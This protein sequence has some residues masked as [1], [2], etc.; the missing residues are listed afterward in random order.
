MENTYRVVNLPKEPT[1]HHLG[2]FGL[3][4]IKE[5][6]PQEICEAGFNA[7]LPYFVKATPAVEATPVVEAAPIVEAEPVEEVKED[8]RVAKK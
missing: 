6:L 5:D 3:V 2:N 1:R 7:G 8:K 4:E